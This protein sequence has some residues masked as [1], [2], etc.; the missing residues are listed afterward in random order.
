M[1]RIQNNSEIKTMFILGKLIPVIETEIK[2]LVEFFDK[3]IYNG[4]KMTDDSL[5]NFIKASFYGKMI[6]LEKIIIPDKII[7]KDKDVKN[8]DKDKDV[9]NPDKEFLGKDDDKKTEEDTDDL[10]NE[11]IGGNDSE[12][13]TGSDDSKTNEK[14]EKDTDNSNNGDNFISDDTGNNDSETGDL[15]YENLNKKSV[16]ELIDLCTENEIQ[17]TRELKRQDLI[18]LLRNVSDEN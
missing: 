14:E 7:S 3:D 18:K 10:T 8:P 6:I 15:S 17:V 16:D 12:E 11:N 1:F 5:F 9:K 2:S 13:N 4:K